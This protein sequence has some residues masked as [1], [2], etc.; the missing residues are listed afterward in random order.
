MHNPKSVEFHQCHAKRHSICF[1]YHIIKNN[2]G[3]FCQDLL[4][5]ENTWLESA[6]AVSCK[7]A[8]CTR[9]TFLFD[10]F[11]SERELKKLL[12]DTLTRTG[13]NSYRQRPSIFWLVC[14]EHAHA[15]YPGLFFSSAL[16]QP[17]YVAGGK[18]SS[19]T[20]LLTSVRIN[21][22]MVVI[23]PPTYKSMRLFRGNIWTWKTYLFF[24]SPPPVP[25]EVDVS[26]LCSLGIWTCITSAA[27]IGDLLSSIGFKPRKNIPLPISNPRCVEV[28]TIAIVGTV[29]KAVVH[30]K[31][32][33]HNSSFTIL[34]DRCWRCV[35]VSYFSETH[36]K[37]KTKKNQT[38]FYILTKTTLLIWRGCTT[39][40]KYKQ[41]RFNFDVHVK[42]K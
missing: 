14:S 41:W 40:L 9:Q 3:N 25:E 5:A 42:G 17:L 16:V 28:C 18:E 8:T 36:H 30:L 4:T 1:F 33:C 32:V 13:I 6:R 35:N 20:G 21:T 7:W 11:F 39:P 15:S 2:E 24:P 38:M 19:G 31:A 29:S 37:K 27:G 22:A 12:R 34:S 23:L 26:F 10:F